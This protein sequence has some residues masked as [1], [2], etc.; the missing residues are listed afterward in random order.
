MKEKHSTVAAFSDREKAEE[1]QKRLTEAGIHAELHDESKWQ[2]Y[3]FLSKPLAGE[4]VEVEEKDFDRAMQVL[5]AEEVKDHVLCGEVRCPRCGSAEVE[6]PQFTRKFIMT[7]FVEVL[8]FLHVLD[9]SF[10]CGKCHHTWPVSET[11]RKTT[12]VLNWPEKDP[13]LVKKE[14]G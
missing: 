5:E 13:A 9:K 10:Y 6:Y 7:T 1:V 12:D 3:W 14:R 11:L 2:K 8:C 4:K